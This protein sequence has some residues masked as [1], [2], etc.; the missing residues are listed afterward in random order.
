M[1]ALLLLGPTGS[2]KS[3]LGNWLETHGL[4]DRRCRHFDFGAHLRAGTGLNASEREFVREVL[5][6]GALLE[7]ETF[8]IA[9]K[10]LRTFIA[11]HEA[12]LLILNGLPR[13]VGQARAIEPIVNVTTVIQ[14]QADA[15]TI[16]ERLRRNSGG[17][18][19]GRVDDDLALVQQKLATFAARTLPLLEHYRQRFARVVTVP[20]KLEMT[21]Q[22]MVSSHSFAVWRARDAEPPKVASR[23][24]DD[25]SSSRAQNRS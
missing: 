16:R 17:D 5:A 8:H 7:N 23:K 18:R 14:L 2:G 25:D 20:V 1:D 15:A 22:E 12:E 19:T 3:P 4:Q 10:I 9:E 11:G 13:H 24:R 6:K 21:P